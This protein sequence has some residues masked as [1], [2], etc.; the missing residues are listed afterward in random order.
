VRHIISKYLGGQ[1][2]DPER[3]EFEAY[4]AEHPE[5]IEELE[6]DAR[7]ESGF[8]HLQKSGTLDA[9]VN[10]GSPRR[11]A[12]PI[13]LAASLIAGVG[14]AVWVGGGPTVRPV[15]LA[16]SVA[17][18]NEAYGGKSLP[19]QAV[20]LLGA[21]S[22]LY[23]AVIELPKTLTVLELHVLL[24]DIQTSAQ[25]QITLLEISSE[26]KRAELG[27]V[28]GLQSDADGFLTVYVDSA[29]LI[30]AQYE[31]RIQG[32]KPASSSRTGSFLIKVVPATTK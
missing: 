31:L 27:T 1:L 28:G 13:A 22:T 5:I 9:L 30:P 4:W 32:E 11:A 21:R 16:A 14:V 15:A 3:T 2:T 10:A 25:Y 18:L 23:D 24:E 6:V 19:V 7:L 20:D 29:R 12:W 17:A 8:A 26:G